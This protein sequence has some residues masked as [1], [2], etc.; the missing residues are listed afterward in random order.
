MN[1]SRNY[2]IALSIIVLLGFIGYTV[3][4]LAKPVPQ[5]I[6]GE[7]DARQIKVAS[8]IVGRID[9]LPVHKGQ[10]I[11][12]GDLLFAI[13][14]PELDAKK[15]QASAVKLVAVAQNSKAE[16]G[17]RV[18]DIQAAYNVWQKA[19]AAVEFAH[20]TY[21]RINNLYTEGVVSEQKKDEIET[22]M[23][24]AVETEKAAKSVYNKAIKGAR[25]EDKNAAQ[26]LVKQADGVL[27]EIDSYL[28]ETQIQAPINGEISNILAERGELIPAG[29]PIVTIVDLNDVWIVFNLTEDLLADIKKGDI[30]PARF[31]AFKMKE[32]NLEIKYINALGDYAT[33]T[34]TKT[35]GD[36]DMK[37]FEV[38][39][40]PVKKV[41]GLRPGMSALVN[42]DKIKE[43]N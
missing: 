25:Y 34:A 41:D 43:K 19:K 4:L 22:K 30:I 20:K 31:P 16:N 3:Y 6:Q 18:E 5:E 28:N 14:S 26:A 36:F 29:Y 23:K 2:I 24:V 39:A 9:S 42:W 40:V 27:S 1:K 21:N 13:S 17:A 33:H 32:I 37:T 10:D 11:N 15:L 38:H 7:V 35:S 8:K 12:K